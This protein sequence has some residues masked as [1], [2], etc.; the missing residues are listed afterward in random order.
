M[1]YDFGLGQ[2]VHSRPFELG[3]APEKTTGLDDIDP[4]AKAGAKPDES[5][6]VLWNIGFEKG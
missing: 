4:N 5:A 6:G 2:I 3:F 1:P